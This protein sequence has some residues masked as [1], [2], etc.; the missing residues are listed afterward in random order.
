PLFAKVDVNGANTN[1]FFQSLKASKPGDISWNF[2]KF[3]INKRG[4]V[5]GRYKSRVVPDSGE[6]LAAIESELAK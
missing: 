3:L 1:P 6:L 4:E 5:V 2:E